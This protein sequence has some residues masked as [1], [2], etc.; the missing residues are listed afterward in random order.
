MSTSRASRVSS[1]ILVTGS[2]RCGSTWAGQTLAR[3]PGIG[4]IDEPYDPN[5]RPGICRA[6]WNQWYAYVSKE[7]AHLHERAIADTLAFRYS[8]AAE[9]GALRSLHDAG[10]MARDAGLWLGRRLRGVRPLMK[11]PIAFFSAPWLAD[12]FGMKVLVLVRHPAAFASSL[13][14]LDWRFR[15][16]NW[17]DQPLLLRDWLGPWEER[18]RAAVADPNRDVIDEAALCWSVIYD[19]AARFRERYPDWLF[20]RHEDLSMDPVGEFARLYERL[21]L[22]MTPEVRSWLERTTGAGNPAEAPTGIS[23]ALTRDSRANT[24]NWIR[25]LGRD[26]ILR[27]RD[28][29]QGV[30]EKWYSEEHWELPQEKA[31]Q[32][33]GVKPV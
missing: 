7:N 28:G 10:R 15:F 3:A 29:T 11:D 16:S 2:H 23:H 13:K 31:P 4:Y 30:A 8:P 33:L 27:L 5:H 6:R 1:P 22:T 32:N 12:R 21:D 9:L 14:R 19:V 26:E 18:I 20:A 17:L 24:R 25:R